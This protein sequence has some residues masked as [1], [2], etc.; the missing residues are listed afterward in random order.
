[1]GI[2]VTWLV[3]KQGGRDREGKKEGKGWE[4]K[5]ENSPNMQ[6]MATIVNNQM[7]TAY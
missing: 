6:G 1:M 5:V 4:E 3:V 7:V 2:I